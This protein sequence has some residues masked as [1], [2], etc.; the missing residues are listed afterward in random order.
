MISHKE[1]NIIALISFFLLIPIVSLYNYYVYHNYLDII[2][3][4]DFEKTNDYE[5]GL[6]I[7]WAECSDIPAVINFIKHFFN[8]TEEELK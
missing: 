3:L 6:G 1:F 4:K 2:S 7:S 8:L 5:N